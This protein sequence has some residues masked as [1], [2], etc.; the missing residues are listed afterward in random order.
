MDAERKLKDAKELAEKS[1][2]LKTEFLAQMSHEIRTPIN[3][4]VS[5]TQLIREQLEDK[6][7]EDLQ[8]AFNSIENSSNR[9]IRTGDLILN[10]SKI[11]TGTHEYNPINLCLCKDVFHEFETQYRR[12]ADQKKIDFEIVCST[13]NSEVF[14]DQYSLIQIFINILDNAFKY[15]EKGLIKIDFEDSDNGSISVKISDSGI[16]IDEQFLPNLFSPFIQEEQGYSR[17]YEG[18]GLGLALVKKYCDLNNAQIN[19]TS[20]KGEGSVFEVLLNKAG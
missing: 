11:Q 18:N 2:K 1:D 10:M 13:K 3:S 17:K 20:K 8:T 4:I 15:T 9:V 19:V 5:F 6:S 12:L 16:G 14:A 7:D